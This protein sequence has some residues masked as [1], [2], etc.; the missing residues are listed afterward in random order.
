MM[1]NAGVS[2]H[3]ALPLPWVQVFSQ[4]LTLVFIGFISISSLR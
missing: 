3:A 1:C 2:G 4:Y